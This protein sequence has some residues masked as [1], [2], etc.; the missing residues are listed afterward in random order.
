MHKSI[1]ILT[2]YY[3]STN[4]GGLLQSYALC[5]YLNDNGVEAR[6][7]FFDASKQSLT[8]PQRIKLRLYYGKKRLKGL[9][10]L[11]AISEIKKRGKSVVG[12]RN[13]IPHTNEIYT[14]KNLS[15]LGDDF[16]AFITGSDQ[17]WNP[18]SINDA[19]SLIFTNKPKYSYAASIASTSIQIGRAHV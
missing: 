10:N 14:Y 19:Y 17:V 2:H 4:Y 11:R 16:D 18:I 6:Q 1:G 13:A 3:N 15:S 8:I 5:R 9:K 12:F 7:V